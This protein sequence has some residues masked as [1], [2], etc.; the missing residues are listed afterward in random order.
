M[1]KVGLFPL[2]LSGFQSLKWVD[3]WCWSRRLVL[4]DS[5]PNLPDNTCRP[6]PTPARGHQR[7]KLQHRDAHKGETRNMHQIKQL[8]CHFC[9]D[10]LPTVHERK[11]GLCSSCL[12]LR[13]DVR[14]VL[15][16]RDRRKQPEK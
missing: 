5:C 15:R 1:P 10:P 16:K 4:S 13:K 7:R 3:V 9:G 11:E 14:E 2:L 6:I 8:Y 12:Q